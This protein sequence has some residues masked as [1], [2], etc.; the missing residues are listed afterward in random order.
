LDPVFENN[1]YARNK[2]VLVVGGSSSGKTR[3]FVFTG[4]FSS[5]LDCHGVF[6]YILCFGQQVVFL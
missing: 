6:F 2:K 1:K 4:D 3:F 5:T